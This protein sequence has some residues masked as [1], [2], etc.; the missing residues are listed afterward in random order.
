MPKKTFE[1]AEK[2]GNDF[3]TQV[4]ENQDQLLQDCKDTA[5]F[6]TQVER[7]QTNEKAHGRIEKRSVSV[8]KTTEFITDP[9]W[10]L[11]LAVIIVVA[12]IRIVYNT[13]TKQWD[14]TQETSY[15][16]CN[17]NKYNS[18]QFYD[19]IRNHW[20]IE[21]CNHYVRDTALKEDASKIRKKPDRMARLRSISLNLMR[22]NGIKNIAQELYRNSLNFRRVCKYKNI[23]D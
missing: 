4:K 13:K 12:R 6:N 23:F 3:L 7:H 21:N 8:H 16:V 14:T 15:Y 22:A 19:A 17:S 20:A 1:I 9:G 2:T 5:R 18:K 11:L 10:K